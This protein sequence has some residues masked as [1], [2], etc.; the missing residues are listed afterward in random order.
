[1]NERLEHIRTDR[2]TLNSASEGPELFKTASFD[3][4]EMTIYSDDSEKITLGQRTV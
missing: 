3:A 2:C 4:V 1:M